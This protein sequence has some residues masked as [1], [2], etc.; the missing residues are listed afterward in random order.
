MPATLAAASNGAR[1]GVLF[2]G[3]VHLEHLGSLKAIAFDKTGTLTNGKP[4]VTDFYVRD[5]ADPDET[6]AILASIESQS[7]H[8]L[9]VAIT[10]YAVDKGITLERNLQIEDV[11]VTVS[12]HLLIH[13]NCL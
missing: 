10:N 11:L 9:A 8:P 3:G 7:N 13:K 5:G 4:V 12:G 2:K 6:L 1:K